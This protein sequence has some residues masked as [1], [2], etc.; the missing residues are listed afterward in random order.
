MSKDWEVKEQATWISGEREFLA[1]GTVVA[2]IVRQEHTWYVKELQEG[3]L[4]Q[5]ELVKGSVI[6][7]EVREATGGQMYRTL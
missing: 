7:T 5:V 6:G 2:K 1:E 3:R 4:G